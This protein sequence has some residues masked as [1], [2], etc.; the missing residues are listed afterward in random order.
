LPVW[1]E[2]LPSAEPAEGEGLT[3]ENAYSLTECFAEVDKPW[4]FRDILSDPTIGRRWEK[5]RRYFF[6]RESTYDMT[7]RCNI[8]CEGCYYYEG[9]APLSDDNRNP[10]AWSE[11]MR[12]ERAR[13]IT[14]VVLAGAEPSLV[15]QLCRVCFEAM[16]LG[17][18]ATNGL[19][20]LPAD[21]GYRIHVSVWG[22]DDTSWRVRRCKD[23]LAKQVENY[24]EDPR[25]V[26]V[27]TFTPQNI[28]EAPA[29]VTALANENC[30]VTFNVFSAPVGYRG[31]LRHSAASLAR[32][33][34][35]MIDLLQRFPAHV[36]FSPY[37]AV[38]HTHRLGLHDLYACAYPRRNAST[39][40]GLGRF[41]RQYRSDLTWD[42]SVACCV[43]GTDCDDCRHY[44]AG[45][46]V[47]TTR[48]LRHAVNPETF[49]AWL[50]YVDTYLAVWVMAYEKGANLLDQPSAPPGCGLSLA[51]CHV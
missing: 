24:R 8:R 2:R 15:P 32:A 11:L 14:Y 45:S 30:R 16:P 12:A 7:R 23:M 6:L 38:A 18:I 3:C 17:T 48:L 31:A 20:S 40:L 19:V 22:N 25:A 37:S 50:D 46:A 5:V 49:A 43:P 44:A 9:G 39:T 26:F 10:A 21:I 35:V 33:R 13:G 41:F 42:R 51:S 36:L 27:Y 28:E 29:V 1:A 47:V 4:K 34:N